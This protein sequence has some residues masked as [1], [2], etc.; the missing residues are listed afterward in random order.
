MDEIKDLK[1]VVKEKLGDLLTPE[2]ETKLGDEKV[3]LD[4]KNFVPL[5][6]LDTA[7]KQITNLEKQLED[8]DKVLQETIAAKEKE[9]KKLVKEA[10]GNPELVKSINDQLEAIKTEKETLKLQVEETKVKSL[11]DK[12]HLAVLEMLMD[13]E[14]LKPT[15]RTMLAREIELSI[16]LDKIELDEIGKVKKSDEIMKPYKENPDYSGFIGKT[17]AVGQRHVQGE[18]DM[19]GDLFT[20]EQLN[21][22]TKEQLLDPKVMAKADKSYAAIGKV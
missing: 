2:M 17:V 11:N 21:S 15:H 3:L 18:I 8:K 13:N 4:A 10:E 7:N 22:L 1:A 5:S 9:L 20:R 6:K 16:G 19:S 14:V 12:K